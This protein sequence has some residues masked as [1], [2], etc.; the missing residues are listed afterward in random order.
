MYRHDNFEDQ[1]YKNYKF[2]TI[3][4]FTTPRLPQFLPKVK[5]NLIRIIVTFKERSCVPNSKRC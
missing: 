4:E 3:A 1:A 5:K 2:K